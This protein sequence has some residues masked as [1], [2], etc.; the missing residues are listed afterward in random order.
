MSAEE[1]LPILTPGLEPT[2]GDSYSPPTNFWDSTS[3][4]AD[5]SNA[6][7]NDAEANKLPEKVE[8]LTLNGEL[9]KDTKRKRVVVVGLGMVGIAF[10]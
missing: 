2:S 6:K 4:T 1:P 3:K 10:M 8:E 7:W 5:M 9:P